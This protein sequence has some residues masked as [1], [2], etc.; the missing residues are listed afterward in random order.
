MIPG[1]PSVG[2]SA[3]DRATAWRLSMVGGAGGVQFD[4][5]SVDV[6][7]IALQCAYRPHGGI[8]RLTDLPDAGR[9]RCSMRDVGGQDVGVAGL[10]AAGQMVGFAW[11]HALWVPLFQFVAPGLTLA[12]GPQRLVAEWG[13][14]L[15]GWALAAWFVRPNR[16]LDG[17]SPIDSLKSRLP[18]VLGAARADRLALT[19]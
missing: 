18:E 8:S 11:H 17:R 2:A 7:F 19:A 10:V 9:V 15:D 5:V 4:P 3:A 14:A 12:D 1:P 16:V 6:A 13:G